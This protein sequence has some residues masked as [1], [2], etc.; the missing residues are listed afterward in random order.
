MVAAEDTRRLRRLTTDLGVTV[1]GRV[2]SYFEGN[3]SAR[4]PVAARGAA[5]PASGSL[6]VTD[7]GHAERVR[8]R[9]PAGRRGR[10]ARRHVTAVPGPS[11]RAHRAGRVA[12]CRS[13]GSASRASC[14]A[15]RA[16]GAAGWPRWPREQRT[17]VFFE[18]PHRTEAALAA[19]AEAFGD[20]RRGGR[21]PRADQDPRG[22]TPRAARRARRV[23]RRRASA[24]R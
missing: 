7:A 20:D 11:R 10:R 23:G 22:G 1:T 4:T 9:L 19:M 15:R 13:T 2:V 17:M 5:R 8:P 6:L 21:V 14:R 16:S 18:A 12:G 3:E 24:A